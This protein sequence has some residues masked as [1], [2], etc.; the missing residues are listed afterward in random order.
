MFETLQSSANPVDN[1]DFKL[2]VEYW[3]SLRNGNITFGTDE[4]E[5]EGERAKN[6]QWTSKNNRSFISCFFYLFIRC[7][8][9]FCA[10]FIRVSN[11]CLNDHILSLVPSNFNGK[12][13]HQRWFQSP[14]LLFVKDSQRRRNP[15][16]L[17]VSSVFF[18]EI[19]FLSPAFTYQH[20]KTFCL[21]GA[22]NFTGNS[23]NF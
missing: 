1:C 16:I 9:F 13:R 11:V 23:F 14:F 5:R 15:Q 20:Y 7:T 12:K 2:S 3:S 22:P 18:L 21:N 4:W 19:V 8:S 10:H 6:R 17:N